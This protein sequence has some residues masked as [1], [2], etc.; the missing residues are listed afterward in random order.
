MLKIVHLLSEETWA[1]NSIE[2][3]A[4]AKIEA[5]LSDMTLAFHRHAAV[6][7]QYRD[8]QDSFRDEKLAK[9]QEGSAQ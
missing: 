6:Y 8:E 2:K 1:A 9:P 5:W 4:V 3:T 7:H